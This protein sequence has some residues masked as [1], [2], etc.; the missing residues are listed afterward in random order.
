MRNSICNT[1]WTK[2]FNI[3]L[4]ISLVLMQSTVHFL[5][6]RKV[7]KCPYLDFNDRLLPSVFRFLSL[8]RINAILYHV[9][10]F[11]SRVVVLLDSNRS[12]PILIS[13]PA[14]LRGMCNETRHFTLF[15]NYLIFILT[16]FMSISISPGNQRKAFGHY[17]TC[18]KRH[19]AFRRLAVSFPFG[20]PR[21]RFV[22]AIGVPSEASI[23]HAEG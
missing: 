23:W 8:S 6:I 12:T 10:L 1:F 17:L 3:F 9:S 11:F 20:M 15:T 7:I 22:P 2:M 4:N 5:L 19:A 18:H 13:L 21:G 16:F 14:C